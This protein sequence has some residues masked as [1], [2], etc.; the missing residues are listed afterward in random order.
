MEDTFCIDH[1]FGE[2][3]MQQIDQ[4]VPKY[5]GQD[6]I[7]SYG[8]FP[9]QVIAN[10][11]N[12]TTDV[13]LNLLL[14]SKYLKL[15]DFDQIKY[16]ISTVQKVTLFLPWDIH[17]D[18]LLP[19][20][21]EGYAPYYNFLIPIHDVQS[22]TI[23]FNQ[24]SNEYSDFYLYKKDHAV[25]DNPIDQQT[26]DNNLSMCWPNDRLYLSIKQML[27]YQRRGQILGFRRNLFH[28]SDNFHTRGIK[29][30]TFIQIRLD[31]KNG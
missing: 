19:T 17:S 2:E 5:L 18:L 11:A 9:N 1:F 16:S 13:E 10:I 3:E 27:P 26:W 4:I 28:S 20:V 24:M 29:S 6:I 25:L 12:L 30:K 15:F 8:V 21:K 23:I 7:H 14:E 22:R 31:I